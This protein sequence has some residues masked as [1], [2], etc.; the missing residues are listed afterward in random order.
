VIIS[1]RGHGPQVVT[2]F[3]GE[4]PKEEMSLMLCELSQED[5]IVEFAS[6]EEI[7]PP[8]PPRIPLIDMTGGDSFVAF[9]CRNQ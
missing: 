1:F 9:V 5:V 4:S 3:L 6:V 2:G 7:D 8:S